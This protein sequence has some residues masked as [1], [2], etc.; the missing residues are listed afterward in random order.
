M[1]RAVL[2]KMGDRGDGVLMVLNLSARAQKWLKSQD[3]DIIDRLI[4]LASGDSFVA[5]RIAKALEIPH[6]RINKK[7]DRTIG[8][9]IV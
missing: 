2:H 4:E 8:L 1:D 9:F 3:L 7:A 6:T 5:V